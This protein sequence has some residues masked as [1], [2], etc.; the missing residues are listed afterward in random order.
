[1]E[2]V[3]LLTELFDKKILSVLNILVNDRSEGMYLGEIARA[4]EVAPATTF[5]IVNKLV[6]IDLVEEQ[7]IKKLKLYKFNR[8]TRSEFLFKLLKKDVQVLKIFIENIK[9]LEGLQAVLLHG[10]EAKDKANILLI[11]HNIDTGK[12]KEIC[13]DIKEK[14]NF[15]IS[16]LSLTAEQYES[17][18][19]M[20]LYSGKK[21][22][23]FEK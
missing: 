11:G 14:Y 22:I 23:L 8:S 7:K 1:M 16:P 21:N 10:E 17:M 20:G 19:K 12:V 18:S 5:R 3:D 2:A 13:A 15:I 9:E 6:D 4:S